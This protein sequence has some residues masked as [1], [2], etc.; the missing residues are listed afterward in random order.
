MSSET[1]EIIFILDR[2]GSMAGLEKDTIGGFNSMVK[3][4][5]EMQLP[6]LITTVLFDDRIE[7]LHDRAKLEDIAPLTEEEYWPR[8]STA[9]FDAT[10]RTITHIRGVHKYIREEDV[11]GKVTVVIT[12]DGYENASREYSRAAVRKLIS[13]QREKG[14][15]FIF[16]GSDIDADAVAEDLDMD[17]GLAF[18]LRKSSESTAATFAGLTQACMSPAASIRD[19]LSSVLEDHLDRKRGRRRK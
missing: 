7:V 1:R 19:K 17:P 2:S 3:K 8:G 10:G 5:K 11:P 16:L 14:W 6:V 9:L 12:T 4:W 13:A 15:E 18:S